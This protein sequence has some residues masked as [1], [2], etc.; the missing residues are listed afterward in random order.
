VFFRLLPNAAEKKV[1]TL[2]GRN[3]DPELVWNLEE[4]ERMAKGLK[5]EVDARFDP[6]AGH[7]LPLLGQ[8]RISAGVQETGPQ[9]DSGLPP[10]GEFVLDGPNVRS[11][12][13]WV[14]RVSPAKVSI[15]ERVPVSA[16][17]DLDGRRRA[18]L[19]AMK[20]KVAKIRWKLAE[21]DSVRSIDLTFDGVVEATVLIRE[22][23]ASPGQHLLVRKG[24]RKVFNETVTADPKTMLEEARRDGRRAQPVY[25]MIAVR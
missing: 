10:E 13:L 6:E 2:C 16:K 25:R 1:M 23:L 3:D 12:W 4:V 5:L 14:N 22:P 17:L 11:P 7:T 18:T 19:N 15:P 24:S 21:A 9:K 20:N 8:D